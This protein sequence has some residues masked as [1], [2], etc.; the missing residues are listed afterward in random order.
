M[1][2]GISPLIAAVILVAIVIGATAIVGPG[3]ISFIRNQASGTGD[4]AIQNI[5]CS[6]AGIYV[7]KATYNTTSNKLRFEVE[8]TGYQELT[9]F[10][11]DA[12]FQDETSTTYSFRGSDEILPSKSSKWFT[13]NR[14]LGKSNFEKII[15]LSETCPTTARGAVENESIEFSG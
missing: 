10:R 8:N 14:T 4:R 6:Q 11:A 12:V 15:V 5:E 2:K 3:I 13:V 1:R 9:G 7:R